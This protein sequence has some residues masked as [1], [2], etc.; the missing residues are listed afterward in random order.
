MTHDHAEDAALCDAALRCG[1]L[2]SIGLIGSSAKWARFRSE[3]AAEGHAA[4]A[5]DRITHAR[6]GCPASPA[7][8]PATIAVGVAA[9]LLAAF[10]R[11]R[12][13]A[14]VPPSE[15]PR[16][17]L[18]RHGPRHPRRP[19][20]RRRA[21]RRGRRRA[22]RRATASSSRAGRSPT[23]RAEHPASRGRRPARRAGAAR[24]RRHPRALPAGAR[25]RRAGHAA[26]RVARAVRPAGGGAAGRRRRTPR[27]WRASSS[28]GW[29]T[30]A[31][32]RRWS[33][34]R[35]SPRPSTR[36]SPQAAR[37]GA[38]GHQRP[39]RQRPG[40]ARRPAHHARAGLRRGPRRW[41]SAGT[42]R[43]ALRYAVTPRFSLSCTDE[44]LDAC[45]RRCSTDVAGVVVHLARQRERR[46]DRRRSRELFDGCRPTSTPTTGTGCVG[47]RAACSPT[48]CTRPTPSSTLLA[49]RGAAVA[50]CPT[51]NCRPGQRAVPAARATCEH[52]VR[53]AL[54][55]DVG[56]GT[57]FSLF[58]EGLQAYFVQ[59]L[60]GD[61]GVPLT[62]AHLLHLATAAG[63]RR[64]RPGARGRRPV[65]S[66]SG[67]TR[68]GCGPRP[69]TPLD[70][71]LR[72]RHA[73]PRTRW[74][75]C[76]RS[77][78][79]PTSPA[80]GWAVGRRRTRRPP[81]PAVAQE[82]SSLS[83]AGRPAGSGSRGSRGRARTRRTAGGPS[84]W[85]RARPLAADSS[86]AA[87]SSSTTWS[88][89]CGVTVSP[90]ARVTPLATARSGCARSPPSRRPP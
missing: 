64:A 62:S 20:R 48:T 22:A 4:D 15:R 88:T 45:A 40:A 52:G 49:A 1:H 16:D 56:A 8:S 89:S 10:E 60:L 23:L 80:S 83:T 34:A 63:R 6:S 17:A 75:R 74:P 13:R 28:A 33:S 12:D 3:L 43:A 18:P 71:V 30:P 53:V 87:Y 27:R 51:S 32:R 47:A 78:A 25:H 90:E 2:G 82:R 42:A 39:G 58:K 57:G 26:A 46:R 7:R 84:Q 21:A 68:S 67:S 44:L 76:S 55:S 59:Q 86:R 72:Q 11:Q 85:P 61:E 35:T 9:D 79:R 38:A 5:I 14:G 77:A 19:V 24:V 73:T 37:V 70:V 65:A 41:P 54:G 69:G 66:A 36:C 50:H 31:R 29:S 81:H